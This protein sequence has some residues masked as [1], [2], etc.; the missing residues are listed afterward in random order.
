MF[1]ARVLGNVVASTKVAGLQGV[2]LLVI[3]PV[4]DDTTTLIGAPLVAADAG[5]AGEG[6]LVTCV[7]SREASLAL[8]PS[9][10]PVDAAVV[11][12]VDSADFGVA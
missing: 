6:D 4:D 11:G 2:K 3:Q 7:T 10:V 8:S 12:I 1:L 9:F 5:Q